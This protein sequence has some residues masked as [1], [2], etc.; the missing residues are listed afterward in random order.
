MYVC[1]HVWKF[2]PPWTRGRNRRG[3]FFGSPSGL[4]RTDRNPRRISELW[5]LPELGDRSRGPKFRRDTETKFTLDRLVRIS[6]HINCIT[7]SSSRGFEAMISVALPRRNLPTSTG[8]S[9]RST[10]RMPTTSVNSK[11]KSADVFP[12]H[13]DTLE[14]G[15]MISCDG[16]GLPS[17]LRTDRPRGRGAEVVTQTAAAGIFWVAVCHD[18]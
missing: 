9:F 3:T 17:Q 18:I 2:N 15:E 12:D 10:M 16:K 4:H 13:E 11:P 5:L 14:Q 1:R 8:Q 6:S 7:V